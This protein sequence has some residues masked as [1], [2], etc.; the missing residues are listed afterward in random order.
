MTGL[1]AATSHTTT[2]APVSFISALISSP[3]RATSSRVTGPATTSTAGV[4]A[5]TVGRPAGRPVLIGTGYARGGCISGRGE[6]AGV[7]DDVGR[8]GKPDGL[9]ELVLKGRWTSPPG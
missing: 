7:D 9:I 8:R 6:L 3:S 5:S 2:A 1:S 4:S